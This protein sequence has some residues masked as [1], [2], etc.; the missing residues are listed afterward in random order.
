MAK[1]GIVVV[2]FNRLQLLQEVITS[3]RYQTYRDSQIVVVNN[4]ST[5]GTL[6]WLTTQTDIVVITQGNVG[7]AGGFYTGMKY[8]AENNFEFC[9]IMD[10]DVVCD[11]NALEALLS[12]YSVESN[13][14]Y[15]CSAVRGIDGSVMNVP[16]VDMTPT[17]NGYPDYYRLIEHQMIKTQNATFVS[18]LFKTSTIKELGLPYKEYFIWGDDTEYTTRIS[19]KYPSYL[20]CKSQVLH[21]RKIQGAILFDTETDKKR[22]K[23]Y[24]YLFR[25]SINNARLHSNFTSLAKAYLRFSFLGTKYFFTLKW[26]KWWIITKS[27]FAAMFFRPK[28]DY[29]KRLD[30]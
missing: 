14:G 16:I 23:N 8:V 18:V 9:W 11:N 15:V 13:I 10:D 24:F 29:P 19:K 21:K 28:V 2:T 5:D 7:G 4:G 27:I 20:V 12:A 26:Y 17:S 3:L 1:V 6:D 30:F 22:L 25:N